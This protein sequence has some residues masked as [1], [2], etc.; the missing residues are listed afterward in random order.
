MVY[1]NAEDFEKYFEARGF[2]IPMTWDEDKINAA[3]L[4]ASEW[5]DNQ[6]EEIWIGFKNTYEQER[7]WPRQ[8]AVVQ[9]YPYYVY[10]RDEIPEE[11]I[12]AT[13]EAAKRELISQ[14]SLSADYT[15]TPY[16]NVSIYNAVTVEYVTGTSAGDVQIQMPIIQNL[17]SKL[18]DSNKSSGGNSLYGKAVRG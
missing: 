11:V 1:G 12:K 3:L 4:V 13:Y 8:L 10:G 15:P 6:Y 14:G 17:M 5:L 2:E 9:S 18:I 7:S 16:T